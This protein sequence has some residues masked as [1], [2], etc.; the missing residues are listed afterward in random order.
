M[1]EEEDYETEN[2]SDF[3]NFP[4]VDSEF[5]DDD[6]S[7]EYAAEDNRYQRDLITSDSA[8][9]I[10]DRIKRATVSKRL[11]ES[12]ISNIRT[13]YSRDAYLSYVRKPDTVLLNLQ[14]DVELAMLSASTHD[15]RKHEVTQIKSLIMNSYPFIV[16]RALDGL[17]R[18]MQGKKRIEQRMGA[19]REYEVIG[20]TPKRKGLMRR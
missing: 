4:W 20:N 17:E 9:A 1:I 11:K 3:E 10:Q 8:K 12:L 13:Y 16:S 19:A 2:T 7:P 15:R 18:D 5:D 6:E 14:Y